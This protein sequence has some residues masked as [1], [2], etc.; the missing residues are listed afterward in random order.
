MQYA[1]ADWKTHGFD[2]WRSCMG[3]GEIIPASEVP[4]KGAFMSDCFQ[5]LPAEVLVG[6]DGL[7]VFDSYVNNM[8][9]VRH[10]ALY[11]A[12]AQLLQRMVPLFERTLSLAAQRP[13][14]VVSE[15]ETE[16]KWDIRTTDEL[17]A[18]LRGTGEMLESG[19]LAEDPGSVLDED[20]LLVLRQERR[21]WVGPALPDKF[22]P[23]RAPPA[24]TLRGRNL[25]VRPT[26]MTSSDENEAPSRQ[27]FSA[28]AARGVDGSALDWGAAADVWRC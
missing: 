14:R 20:A 22:E 3:A 16:D 13:Q 28:V 6:E 26:A 1:A 8:H 17:V 12:T 24:V 5:W 10:A 2:A 23:A 7:V 9:P 18:R 27:H 19:A 11:A 4:R 15:G 21:R 25:Q